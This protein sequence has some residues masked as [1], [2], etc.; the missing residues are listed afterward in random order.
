MHQAQKQY[1]TRICRHAHKHEHTHIVNY[2]DE[3]L[4]RRKAGYA[5][6]HYEAQGVRQIKLFPA[7]GTKRAGINKIQLYHCMTSKPKRGYRLLSPRTKRRARLPWKQHSTQNPPSLSFA[8]ALFYNWPEDSICGVTI[9]TCCWGRPAT[10]A[11]GIGVC[12]CRPDVL[13][14]SGNKGT[15]QNRALVNNP[16]V[17]HWTDFDPMSWVDLVTLAQ[18]KTQL[19]WTTP[20]YNTDQIST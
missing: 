20:V 2:C 5:E 15:E 13:G 19:S 6:H 7:N 12:C 9:C 8:V 18:N 16:D 3:C 11:A 17:Q 10:E 4:P 1:L 14:W